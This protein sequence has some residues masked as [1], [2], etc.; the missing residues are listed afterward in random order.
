APALPRGART[1]PAS[2]LLPRGVPPR[3]VDPPLG[4]E[5]GDR[6]EGR[7]DRRPPGPPPPRR[8]ALAPRSRFRDGVLDR[9]P[10]RSV[11]NPRVRGRGV[12]GPDE[13]APVRPPPRPVRPPVRVRGRVPSRRGRPCRG[14]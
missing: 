8:R 14:R 10:A 5:D 9:V 13:Q 7:P 4:R 11:P 1:R 2:S 12:R 3:P 6:R